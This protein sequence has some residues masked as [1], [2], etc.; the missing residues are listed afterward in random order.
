MIDIRTDLACSCASLC[1]PVIKLEIYIH[2]KLFSVFRS[3][4]SGTAIGLH[5]SGNSRFNFDFEAR[6]DVSL[7][8]AL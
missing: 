8:R 3:A 1:A 5:N 4:S 2:H 7:P 6:C